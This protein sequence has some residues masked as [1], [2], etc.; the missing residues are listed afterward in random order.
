M[1]AFTLLSINAACLLSGRVL[2]IDYAEMR[3]MAGWLS[4]WLGVCRNK[5]GDDGMKLLADV[6]EL[7][8][9]GCSVCGCGGCCL[10]VAVA[11][12]DVAC[13]CFIRR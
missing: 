8:G 2:V 3:P 7:P 13:L 6:R 10:A 12:A 5:L 1:H 11:A 9:C 4:G